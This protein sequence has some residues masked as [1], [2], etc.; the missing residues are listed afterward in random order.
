MTETASRPWWR[1]PPREGVLVAL[2]ALAALRLLVILIQPLLTPPQW[3]EFI[4]LANAKRIFNGALPYRDYF[5]HTPP[6]A[7]WFYAALFWLSGGPNAGIARLVTQVAVVGSGVL[8]YA[9]LRRLA[10]RPLAAALPGVALI[11]LWFPQWPIALH[12]WLALLPASAALLCWTQALRAD[13]ARQRATALWAGAS[14]ALLVATALAVQTQAVIASATLL[15]LP[16]TLRWLRPHWATPAP[17]PL[18]SGLIG[19]GVLAA[20]AFLGYLAASGTLGLFVDNSL[21]FPLRSYR[22]PGGPNDLPF[23]ADVPYRL[24]VFAGL[25]APAWLRSMLAAGQICSVLAAI[26]AAL[27]LATTA[28]RALLERRP[29]PDRRRWRDAAALLLPFLAA[30]GCLLARPDVL[31]LSF[32]ALLPTAIAVLA[33]DASLRLHAWYIDRCARALIAL[34]CAIGLTAH[35]LLPLARGAPVPPLFGRLA[36]IDP[37]LDGLP[38]IDGEMVQA[39]PRLYFLRRFGV[40]HP[41][42]RLFAASQGAVA[43][44]FGLEPAVT[45]TLLLAPQTSYNR[46]E[47]YG[48]AAAQL[49]AR[50]PELVMITP[51][52]DVPGFLRP[53]P[54]APGQVLELARVLTTGYTAAGRIGNALVLVRTDLMQAASAPAPGGQ[55]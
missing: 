28:L 39:D 19:G 5:N 38:V 16:R 53:P 1:T 54:N 6:G 41:G 42:A 18:W 29:L 15:A 21:L 7:E 20:G 31:H 17:R 10:L 9:A 8:V 40:D 49:Q 45:E 25:E 2:A 30:F 27:W 37:A 34:C 3:D 13:P 26:A 44:F 36:S 4:I 43:Y 48:R 24:G 22:Q 23:L 50:P 47:A 52:D 12:H 32:Y 55:R 35:L 51:L 33:A 46:P 14:G 11:A